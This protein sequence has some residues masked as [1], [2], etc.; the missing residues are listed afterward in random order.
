M[1]WRLTFECTLAAWLIA[2]A[3]HGV[4]LTD[5]PAVPVAALPSLSLPTNVLPDAPKPARVRRRL[6]PRLPP[7]SAR[8]GTAPLTFGPVPSSGLSITAPDH[9]LIRP[10]APVFTPAPIP[11]RDAS[12]PTGPRATSAAQLA[13]G[14]FT[15]RPSYRGDAYTPNSSAQTDQDRRTRPAAG[16]NL[17][18]PLTGQ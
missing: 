11:D 14:V 9:P 16:F 1:I 18:M 17:R 3:A 2:G 10:G 8:A 7:L 12:G 4:E 5:A 15:R 13:P 6:P